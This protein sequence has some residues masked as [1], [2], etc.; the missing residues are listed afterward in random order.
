[1]NY[2]VQNA[3]RWKF[4]HPLDKPVNWAQEKPVSGHFL[5]DV[6]ETTTNQVIKTDMTQS[7]AKALVRHLNMGGGFDGN[8]PAFFLERLILTGD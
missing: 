3:G 5:H 1:M 7:E 2:K 4:D 8:T 6:V